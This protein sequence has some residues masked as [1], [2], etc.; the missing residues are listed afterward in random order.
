MLV[1]SATRFRLPGGLRAAPT[2]PHEQH[3]D[4]GQWSFASDADA[5]D[6]TVRFE[7]RVRAGE[8]APEQ[9]Q[10]YRAA[11]EAALTPLRRQLVLAPEGSAAHV[12]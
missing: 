2:Q 11:M 8:H 12:E 1:R 7:C 9:F 5:T 3:S 10:A 6:L 4:F